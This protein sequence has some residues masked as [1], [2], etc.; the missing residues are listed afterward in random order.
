MK[1]RSAFLSILMT[2]MACTPAFCADWWEQAGNGDTLDQ[3]DVEQGDS[4]GPLETAVRVNWVDDYIEVVA[5]GTVDSEKAVNNAHA[6]SMAKKT[7]RHLAYEKLAETIN[8]ISITSDATYDRELMVDS[9]LKTEVQALVRGAQVIDENHDQLSDGSIWARVRLGI[10]ITG[11]K[12]LMSSSESWIE[13]NQDSLE[14]DNFADSGEESKTSEENETGEEVSGLIIDAG[15]LDL[16]PAMVP[17]IYSEGGELIYG[18]GDVDNSYLTRQGIA[19]YA[20]SID[21]ARSN[22]RVGENPMVV[23]AEKI[24]GEN[25]CDVVIPV[26]EASKLMKASSDN[27]FLE[28]CR[29]MF[30]V[31]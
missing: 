18:P 22:E 31:N 6:L 17:K 27:D 20:R 4:A 19:G 8:G 7:A 13:K 12:S 23:K 24:R 11:P 14:S 3:K 25:N 15:G 16:K 5:G 26:D 9:N 30:V 21:Q 28:E 2:I 10:H 29:V 1:F